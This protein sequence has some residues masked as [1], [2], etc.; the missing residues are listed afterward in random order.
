EGRRGSRRATAGAGPR[1]LRHI[2][3]VF[4]RHQVREGGARIERRELL[5]PA[6]RLAVDEDLRHR[7]PAG[8]RDEGGAERRIVGDVDLVVADAAG[9]EPTPPAHAERAAPPRVG[10]DSPPPA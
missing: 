9:V 8:P 3:A 1:P 10:L 2:A 4:A 7:A 5:D 6:D